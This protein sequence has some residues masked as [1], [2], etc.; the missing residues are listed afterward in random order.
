MK[1]RYGLIGGGNGGFIGG[2]H[3]R[4]ADF[5][6]ACELSA[7]CFSR[8]QEANLQ[9][10]TL[11]GVTPERTYSSFQEMAEAE[12]NRE[13]GVDFI[14]IATPNFTHYEIAR[15]FLEHGIHVICDK[16]VALDSVQAEELC[17]L[18]EERGLLFG[19]C[20]TYANYAILQEARRMIREGMLGELFSI[21]AEYPQ[22]W[23]LTPDDTDVMSDWL[24]D[25]EKTGKAGCTAHI[26][27][28][29]EYLMRY[30]TGAKP[31]RI[32]ARFQ[33]YPRNLP[34]ETE[35]QVMI[36]YENQ[37]QGLMWA[38][39][40][41]AGNDCGIALRVFGSRGSLEWSHLNPSRLIYRPLNQ[42]SQTLVCGRNYLGEEAG[43]LARL[44]AGHPEGFYEAFANIF[45]NFC[46][47]LKLL[48]EGR[49][50]KELH[51]PTIEDGLLS[52]RFIEACVKSNEN[53]N[54]WVELER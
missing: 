41:A 7:G 12:G 11:W 48:K 17:S 18:A 25:P 5:D 14:S 27:T 2:V 19:V 45:Q 37:I 4:A 22:D 32:L 49:R 26:G 39:I 33:T 51:F 23:I 8:K 38:S 46:G 54:A 6:F 35:S 21:V 24:M 13:D 47:D 44:P 9:T 16:P 28:H 1:L 52:M 40:A 43:R 20:Y 31:R 34:L 29:L 36:D 10:G 30:V 42:P 3:R 50:P 53:N 15:T